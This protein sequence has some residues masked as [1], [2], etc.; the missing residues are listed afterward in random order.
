MAEGHH[1]QL[2]ELFERA[3]E[4]S[5]EGRRQFLEICTDDPAIRS[6]L[7]SLLAAHDRAPNLLERL[8]DDVLPAALQAVA[9]ED[10]VNGPRGRV[11][12][13]IVSTSERSGGDAAV[14][15]E[16]GARLGG[17]EIEGRIAAGGIGVVY[18]AFDA[19]LQ[20]SVAIKTLAWSTPDARASILREARA[21]SALNHPHI[22]TIHEVGEHES[23]P[24]IA[25]EYID[26]RTLRDLIPPDGLPAESIVRYGVQV[27][28]AV[29]YAH[30]HGI[31]HRDLKSAN[32]M[33]SAEGHVK[34][35]D[36]GLAMRLPAAEMETVTRMRAAAANE[37]PLAGT[38]AYLAPELLR[39]SAADR[40]SDV[41]ALG[42]LVYEM[43]GGRLPFQGATPFELTAAILNG[44]RP[45][46]P[47]TLPMPLQSVIGK[48]LARDPAQR[49][50]DAGELRVALETVQLG[51]DPSLA[52]RDE[53]PRAVRRAPRWR[54]PLLIAGVTVLVL[55][56]AVG[57][58]LFNAKRTLALTDRDTLLVADFVNT[59]GDGVFDRTLKQALSIHLEQSPF[60]SVVSR[61][62]ERAMLRLMTKAP[63]DRLAGPVAREACQRIGAKAMIEGTIAPVGSHYVVG[64]DALNCESGATIGSEQAEAS[65]RE[66]VLTV[67]GAAASRLRRKLG[68]SLPTV[69][70][71]DKPLEQA[72]TSSLEAFQAFSAA[73]DIR[74]RTS[75]LGAVPFYR[76]AIELDPD[77]ALAYAR[78]SAVYWNLGQ[79]AEGNR[80]AEEA[81]ARRD[82]V[83]ER[84]RFYIDGQHCGLTADPD[85]GR[86]VQELWKRTYP[87]DG[88]PYGNLSNW[89]YGA[90]MCD[91][92]LETAEEALRLGP[93]YS[94]PYA[95][96][97]RA[98]LCLE[99]PA[100][101]Q[102]T[103]EQALS[104]HLESP[105]I[106]TVLF[107]V[108]FYERDHRAIQRVRE[109]ASGQPEESL[110]KEFESDAAAF[111]GQM[112]RSRELR[113]H[114]ERLAA[115]RLKE[116]VLPTRA[117]GA[118]C[119]AAQGNFQRARDSVKSIAAESHPASVTPLLLTAALLARDYD[120][121]DV[122]LRG[123]S[124]LLNQGPIALL[125]AVVRVLR[126]VV[127]GDR[128]AI[129]RL[130]PASPREL[131]LVA[132]PAYVRGLVY[133][134]ARDGGKAAAE[135]QRI[136]D[137]RGFEAISPMYPLA[138][139]QQARAYVLMGEHTKARKTYQDFL[140]L[141][142]DADPEIPIL[143]EAK[144]EYAQLLVR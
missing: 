51:S 38:L 134:E 91:K 122:L 138:H 32:V 19:V 42:V 135:F 89:Y 108:A 1:D 87:R 96:V 10:R 144:A 77:F 112:R 72:T 83:S 59:T 100:E 140:A 142:K 111:D 29:E 105:F 21:A 88:R 39:G 41:W 18:R 7:R 86:N 24:F 55:A 123:R 74:S 56:G 110:F 137:H 94:Q 70:R 58:M 114:A 62:E 54:R 31:I 13:A 125:D 43:A 6:E 16:P 26:G 106:Y 37:G 48:C 118:V 67:L 22:C 9:D 3:V 141:W 79:A 107:R 109:W 11:N 115:V 129:S 113:L 124:E 93:G 71:F 136:L 84:E 49:Y 121:A 60:L 126:E 90:L 28:Q 69:Q 80:N 98:Y 116:S 44:T 4:L 25:M 127:A 33:I 131:T 120:Q 78:L 73:E 52:W 40:R 63:A 20:R 82:R 85:C 132:Y 45:A 92:A 53:S 66:Q 8:A 17:Y 117:R 68:E 143:R 14:T 36:F 133:L 12:P 103:L 34:V 101:A 128:S 61:E 46:L 130:P 104:R 64:L 139:V 75:E 5:P 95:Y 50:R 76:R 99:K 81:Y 23:V 119:E 15:I 2:S 97:A 27:A 47:A 65:S 30:R 35:L 57:M 102:R